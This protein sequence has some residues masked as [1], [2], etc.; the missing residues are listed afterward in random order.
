MPYLISLCNLYRK[1]E[2]PVFFFWFFLGGG[3]GATFAKNVLWHFA[4]EHTASVF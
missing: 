4:L 2:Q 3:V 1:T